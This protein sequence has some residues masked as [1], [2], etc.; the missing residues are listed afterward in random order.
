MQK[1]LIF[2][3]FASLPLEEF[4]QRIV[5][6]FRQ[7][8]GRLVAPDPLGAV[9]VEFR[10]P[11]PL[12]DLE[13]PVSVYGYGYQLHYEDDLQGVRCATHA[14]WFSDLCINYIYTGYELI[15]IDRY[16]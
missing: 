4:K 9:M 7:L 12:G 3:I 15:C 5:K 6:F 11:V 2:D 14:V 10:S 1:V 13:Q 8:I 16:S